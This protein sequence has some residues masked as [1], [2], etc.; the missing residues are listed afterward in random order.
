MPVAF[1]RALGKRESNLNPAEAKDPAWGLLQVIPSVRTSHNKRRGTSYSQGDLLDP[2]INVRIVTDLL[3]RIVTAYGKHPSA[4]MQEDWTN[5]EF[6]NLITA[7]WNSGYSEAAGVGHV[8]SW[9]EAHGI[10]VTHDAVFEYAG[11]AAGTRHLQNDKKRSWQK[12][13]TELYF[14]QPDAGKAAGGLLALA[15][16]GFFAWAAYRLL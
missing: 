13:V 10:P 12:T 7:G 2:E 11:P 9:L 6:V 5:P 1:L 15:V 14:A 3:N 8:A 16:V 4:N